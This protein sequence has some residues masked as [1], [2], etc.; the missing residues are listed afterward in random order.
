MEMRRTRRRALPG[1]LKRQVLACSLSL[2]FILMGCM[3]SHLLTAR[4]DAAAL[5]IPHKG[6]LPLLDEDRNAPPFLKAAFEPSSDSAHTDVSLAR[7][8][9]HEPAMVA[10]LAVPRNAYIPPSPLEEDAKQAETTPTRVPQEPIA[11]PT[12]AATTPVEPAAPARPAPVEGKVK[13]GQTAFSIFRQ[14]GVT[15]AQV[16]ELQQAIHSVYNLR[17]L[18]VG[19]PYRIELAPDGA[20]QHFTYE[21]DAQ[22]QLEVA[23]DAQTFVA[24]IEPI[25][26]E[27]RERV[28]SGHIDA[29]LYMSLITQGESPQLVSDFANIFAWSVDFDTDLQPGDSFRLLIEEHWRSGTIP[30]YHRILAAELVTKDHSLQAVYYVHNKQG[31]YYQPDGR[32]L[33]GMFLRSPLQYTRISSLF[34]PRRFHPILKRYRPHLGVDY[35][36]PYGTPVR[37][38]AAGTVTWAGRKGANGKMVKIY[39]NNTY[40]TYYLHLSRVARGV[41]RGARVAQGQVIGYVG[42]TGLS[43]GPHLDFRLTQHGTYINPLTHKSVEAA[44]LPQKTLP[45]F[46]TYAENTL[47][48]LSLSTSLL[49]R[50]ASKAGQE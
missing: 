11:A 4:Q 40:T 31:A 49:Q 35:A 15:V 42:S 32:S 24:Q 1:G 29:S 30:Q 48:K 37:S 34:S 23:R 12:A 43:T 47:A 33:R 28:L 44:P 18:R 22:R 27:R 26:Y 41:Q 7:G 21:I 10:A 6:S 9:T 20:L 39:H 36:A 5:A 16:S 2:L 19:Q 17:H 25:H 13:K 8:P 38:V 45:A 14:A 46:R 50:S 3:G